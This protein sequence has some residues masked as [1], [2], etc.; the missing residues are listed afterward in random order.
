[1]QAG[2]GFRHGAW[3][4]ARE[5]RSTRLRPLTAGDVPEPKNSPSC[6]G[7]IADFPP[8]CRPKRPPRL[9]ED[10]PRG[11]REPHTKSPERARPPDHRGYIYAVDR[12]STGL[13]IAQATGRGDPIS[14]GLITG[15]EASRRLAWHSRSRAWSPDL[16]SCRLAPEESRYAGLPA[17]SSTVS[18]TLS[19]TES[20]PPAL[21][22]TASHSV[23]MR[24]L[25]WRNGFRAYRVSARQ[26]DRPLVYRRRLY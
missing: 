3:Y 5:S 26:N 17:L 1:M 22:A 10:R 14:S 12:S 11:A 9:T 20:R 6:L 24:Q 13:Q 2:D 4:S 16:T 15:P 23:G 18:G 21:S 25:L 8:P 7:S 19:S